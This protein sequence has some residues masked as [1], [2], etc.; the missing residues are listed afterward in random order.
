[1]VIN[2]FVGGEEMLCVF[3]CPHCNANMKYDIMKQMLVCESCNSE[4]DIDDFDNNNIEFEGKIEIE[5]GLQKM[6]CPGCGANIITSVSNVKVNCCYCDTELALFGTAEG[7]ISPELIIGSKITRQEAENQVI[8]WWMHHDSLPKFDRKKMKLE[9]DHVYIPVWL[10]DI[11]AITDISGTISWSQIKG[12]AYNNYAGLS[13]E[14][15]A[16]LKNAQIGHKN[17]GVDED[18]VDRY[19]RD[20]RFKGDTI[21]FSHGSKIENPVIR[22]SIDVRKKIQ[23]IFTK[24][25]I[26]GSTHFSTERFKGIEPYNYS[27]L[28]EFNPAYLVSHKAEN[29]QMTKEEATLFAMRDAKKYG[30][31]QAKI[32]MA[33]EGGPTGNL[34]DIIRKRTTAHPKGIYYGL[35]PVW[36]CS[37]TYNRSKHFIYVNGQTGKTDGELFVAKDGLKGELLSYGILNMIYWFGLLLLCVSICTDYIGNIFLILGILILYVFFGIAFRRGPIAKLIYKEDEVTFVP[38]IQSAEKISDGFINIVKAIAGVFFSVL[39]ISFCIKINKLSKLVFNIPIT[40]AIAIIV[41]L[42][43]TYFYYNKKIKELT[44]D[45]GAE[46][47]DYVPDC[48]TVV[49]ETKRLN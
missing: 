20:E 14:S 26:N 19:I 18:F 8:K 16:L 31:E 1:M 5:D 32:H 39:G 43:V 30:D 11:Q 13:E 29:P 2:I 25:P 45:R 38:E 40:F 35:L 34:D 37:Y 47:S 6:N 15:K 7:E 22:R 24:L 41:T 48:G 17:I 4:L 49:L 9:F 23:S 12:V 42:F 36:I 27:E 46:Y 28:E 10:S 33:A 21:D 3:K 44:K